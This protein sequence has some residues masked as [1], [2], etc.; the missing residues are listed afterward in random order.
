[1]DIGT[2]AVVEVATE[3]IDVVLEATEKVEDAETD[4]M[5]TCVKLRLNTT[6]AFVLLLAAYPT[7]PKEF[8][9]NSL[10]KYVE[11]FV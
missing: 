2:L 4:E 11:G 8:K 10:N 9:L 7:V 1:V 3:S 5:L 6:K